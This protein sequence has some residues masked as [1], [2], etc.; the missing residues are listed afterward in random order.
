MAKDEITVDEALARVVEVVRRDMVNAE[1]TDAGRDYA[2]LGWPEFWVAMDKLV[3]AYGRENGMEV[4]GAVVDYEGDEPVPS[5]GFTGVDNPRVARAERNRKMVKTEVVPMEEDH[6]EGSGEGGKNVGEQVP[7]NEEDNRSGTG[8]GEEVPDKDDEAAGGD[9]PEEGEGLARADRDNPEEVDNVE[10]RE[11][12]GDHDVIHRTGDE[13]RVD[14]EV[15]S[16]GV[17]ETDED[18]PV[19]P[20]DNAV[21]IAHT[22]R[23]DDKID[24]DNGGD[25]FDSSGD[26]EQNEETAKND[27]DNI[28][29]R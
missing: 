19:V 8:D 17:E 18:A 6:E 9:V 3:E 23:V 27:Q 2:R 12:F 29:N 14:N 28:D 13:L 26:P 25:L 24:N 20:G 21:K 7:A 1:H 10:E 22:N 5:A 16:R 4:E 15:M 11:A